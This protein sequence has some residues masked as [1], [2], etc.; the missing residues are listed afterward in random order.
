MRTIKSWWLILA[1]ISGFALAMFAEELVLTWREDRLEF[2]APHVHFIGGR[3]LELLHNAAPVP[4]DFQLT[5]WSGTRNHEFRTIRDQFVISY[6]LWQQDF[7][8]V[9]T[10]SPQKRV[11]HLSAQ[12]A[13]AWCW[14]QISDQM[15]EGLHTLNAAEPFWARLEIRAEDGKDGPLFGRPLTEAGISLTSLIEIFS[16]PPQSQ[17]THWGP[18]EAGPFRL[19]E[20]KRAPQ[21]GS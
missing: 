6:D 9:K 5:I 17:Q 1:F 13:E 4:F 15:S 8:V 18:F 21:R 2:S 14:R 11:D 19:A 10:P 16:R 3:P 12:A 7:R 20:L